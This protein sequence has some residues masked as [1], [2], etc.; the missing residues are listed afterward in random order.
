MS[1]RIFFAGAAAGV[2]STSPGPVPVVGVVISPSVTSVGALGVGDEPCG[3]RVDCNFL[4]D[5]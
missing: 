4:H 2:V 1:F 5:S 3:R